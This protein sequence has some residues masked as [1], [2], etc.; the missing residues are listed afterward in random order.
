MKRILF[1][2]ILAVVTV[3]MLVFGF[4]SGYVHEC[5]KKFDKLPSGTGACYLGK[6]REGMP[7]GFGVMEWSDGRRYMGEF[8]GPIPTGE[9][10]MTTPSGMRYEGISVDSDVLSKTHGILTW[11][12]GRCY[13]GQF[14]LMWPR[15]F[16]FITYPDGRILSGHFPRHGG[17]NPYL[18]R[19]P[20]DPNLPSKGAIFTMPDG[21]ILI[22]GTN[23]HGLP[24]DRSFERPLTTINETL[25][26][27]PHQYRQLQMGKSLS[28][29]SST[30]DLSLLLGDIER[31]KYHLA[32]TPIPP[33][34][35]AVRVVFD[36]FKTPFGV[37]KLYRDMQE[38][39]KHKNEIVKH[40]RSLQ[41]RCP[42]PR[43]S[44]DDGEP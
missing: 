16:G 15:G 39:N 34:S 17:E 28:Q 44:R 27:T 9:G 7:Y 21:R 29:V 14:V 40:H 32:V 6:L 35:R 23:L 4:G 13:E 36:I 11:P 25:R 10:V 1:C 19:G 41:R 3:G 37:S 18:S 20:L 43:A 42:N 33:F 2:T 26:I 38:L 12:D 30:L 31:L 22:G 5:D 8:R 24:V